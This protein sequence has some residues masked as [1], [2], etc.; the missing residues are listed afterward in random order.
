MS[1]RTVR[2]ATPDHKWRIVVPHVQGPRQLWAAASTGLL[3]L[4]LGCEK[5]QQ[6]SGSRW[7]D[8]AEAASR[9]RDASAQDQNWGDGASCGR[10]RRRRERSVCTYAQVRHR[11]AGWRFSDSSGALA[12]TGIVGAFALRFECESAA[13]VDAKRGVSSRRLVKTVARL[14]RGWLPCRGRLL[15]RALS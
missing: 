14:S 9:A 3:V 4:L 2:R 5:R 15:D 1:V 13:R 8:G 6:Q 7:G 12:G 11:R 10:R